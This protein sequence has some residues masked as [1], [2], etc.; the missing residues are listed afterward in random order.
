MPIISRAR[1]TNEYVGIAKM[2][3]DSRRPRRLAIVIRA[4]TAT[5]IS[6]LTGSSSGTTETIWPI[7]DAVDTATVIT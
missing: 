2:F 7:A 3:P 5:A 6:I 4:M 1:T